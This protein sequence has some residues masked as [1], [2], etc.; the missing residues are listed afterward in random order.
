MAQCDIVCE[1]FPCDIIFNNK[2]RKTSLCVPRGKSGWTQHWRRKRGWHSCN[3]KGAAGDTDQML[4]HCLRNFLKKI[5]VFPK[6]CLSL[7]MKMS[8][9][10]S[11]ACRCGAQAWLCWVHMPRTADGQY[12][13]TLL[14]AA[15]PL[16]REICSNLLTLSSTGFFNFQGNLKSLGSFFST[17]FFNFP[18]IELQGF[19]TYCRHGNP[20][21][22]MP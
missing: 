22:V 1:A 8:H 20:P 7:Y 19:F 11:S 21:S 4:P 2:E 5:P 16:L 14:S 9:T 13:S 17:D 3:V 6:L 18:S 10:N 12:L 15:L